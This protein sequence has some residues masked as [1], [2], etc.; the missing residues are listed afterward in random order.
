MN[1]KW[2]F[3]CTLPMSSAFNTGAH[4]NRQFRIIFILYM[5]YC[6]N[7][8]RNAATSQKE[9]SCAHKRTTKAKEMTEIAT[10]ARNTYRAPAATEW[11]VLRRSPKIVLT[12]GFCL[13]DDQRWSTTMWIG[14]LRIKTIIYILLGSMN[15]KSNWH[16]RES[17]AKAY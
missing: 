14:S 8:L 17:K 5:I 15:I 2:N 10:G 16:W 4:N 3:A 11:N 1:E 13:H 7:I 9:Q 12:F 6:D